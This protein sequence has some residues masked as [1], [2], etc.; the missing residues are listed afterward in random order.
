MQ[1]TRSEMIVTKT[2]CLCL[3]L[4][5]LLCFLGSPAIL[6]AD[7]GG[8][9][10]SQPPLSEQIAHKA[11][12]WG[13]DVTVAEGPV[14]GG[15]SLASDTSGNLYAVRCS[16][17]NGVP[18]AHIAVYKSTDGGESW[19][20]FAAFY[21]TLASYSHPVVLT[22][23]NT[24][25]VYLFYLYPYQSKRIQM[26]RYTQSGV[27]EGTYDVKL[28]TDSITYYSACTDLGIGDHLMVVYERKEMGDNTPDL[29]SVL[30]TDKGETWSTEVKITEDGSHPDI[31]YG[32]DGYLYCVHEKTGGTDTEIAFIRSSDYGMSWELGTGEY[33]TGDSYDDT[34]PKVAALH[35]LPADGAHVWV[36]YNH[37]WSTAKGDDTLEYHGT[38]TYFWC[39]PDSYGDD[40]FS[41]RFTPAWYYTL[42]SAQLMFYDYGF[43]GSNGV[44]VYLWNSDG[45]L[46]TTKVD[47]VDIDYG[48]LQ[49]FPTW[50]T[51]D[52]S[53]KNITLCPV[54]DFHIG[55][56][57]LG[58]DTIAIITDEGEDP[59]GSECRSSAHSS[60]GWG[61]MCD[62]QGW[63]Y[64]FF[65]R[66]VVEPTAGTGIDLRY[67]YSTNS[68]VD[69]SKD[70]ILANDPDYDEMACDLWAKPDQ[71]DNWM[72]ICYLKH[73]WI[74]V[75]P[76]TYIEVSNVNRGYTQ[77][78]D[79]TSWF[80]TRISDHSAAMS[81]DGREICQGAYTGNQECILYAGKSYPGNFEK[82]YF[83]NG[84]WTD[85]EDETASQDAIPA[86]TLSANYPN[87]F[88]P[89]TKIDYFIPSACHVRLDI[90]N[91]L[92]QHV[93]TLV[94][95]DQFAGE[96]VVA[97]D[98]KNQRGESVT[99]GIYLYRL[100]AGEF[101]QSKK[102]IL[103]R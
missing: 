20:W 31:V 100:E 55:Y 59:A 73:G 90:F 30:S 97:W 70:H 51:V 9:Q 10:Y 69:W 65:I 91:V 18:D 79:P 76:Y 68:G 75:P 98:G 86:F 94:D 1:S 26:K 57:S 83:D 40:M 61:T 42:K 19:S 89:E 84:G 54:S 15:I 72:S 74:F 44:R 50:T 13:N 32:N 21:S 8:F 78:L 63:G 49:W 53:S 43:V 77:S 25:K 87:P 67:A 52:F 28:D 37:D 27:L 102:M 36:V 16:T 14:E 82:L 92:G 41:V 22:G 2:I 3:S 93:R 56:R 29:Y 96:K 11:F 66:A 33:L 47:S 95:E 39:C 103:I 12:T 101:I 64:N 58:N 99:S 24:N 48:C 60:G 81:E 46:P 38:V 17:W 80:H 85:V 7:G 71:T 23:K 4:M 6:A 34:Y 88:N 62:D 35:T 45:Q 5:V